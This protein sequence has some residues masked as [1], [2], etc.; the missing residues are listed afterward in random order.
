VLRLKQTSTSKLE[1]PWEGPYL[2]HEAIPG[3]TYRLGGHQ[4]PMERIAA[5]SILSLESA[6]FLPLLSLCNQ[7]SAADH[8]Q[9]LRP[10]RQAIKCVSSYYSPT[11]ARGLRFKKLL[12]PRSGASP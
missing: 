9:Q 2:V 5:V 10:R 7:A 1:S 6:Y 12:N 11:H 4:K 8:A 3:G